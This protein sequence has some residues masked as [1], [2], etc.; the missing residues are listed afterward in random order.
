MLPLVKKTMKTKADTMDMLDDW[1]ISKI[2]DSSENPDFGFIETLYQTCS[3]ALVSL[4]KS[5]FRSTTHNRQKGILKKDIASIHFW[6]ENF[7]TGH[8]D[9]ILTESSDLKI[10]VLENLTGIGKILIPLFTDYGEAT[11]S[12]NSKRYSEVNFLKELNTQVEKATLMLDVEERSDPS[13]DDESDDFTPATERHQNR[14]GRLH[15]YTSC[16]IGLTPVVERYIWSLQRKAEIQYV[17][18]ETGFHS[19]HRAQ[20]YAMRIRD[21]FSNAAAALVERLAEANLERSIRLRTKQEGEEVDGHTNEDAVTLFKPFSLFHDSGLGTSIPTISQYAATVASHTSFISVAGEDAIGR[22]RVPSLPQ[23]GGRPFQ[24]EYCRKTISMRNRIEWKMHVFADLESYICTHDECKDALKTFPTRQ[25]WADHEFNEHFTL[26]QWRCFTCS[27]TLGSP[28]LYVEHLTQVHDFVL[29][30]HYLTAV[31]SEARET[32]LTPEFETFRC[33][34]CLQDG[35]Q[36]K[37]K[38]STHV[39]RHLEEIS[40]ACLP[41]DEEESTDDGLDTDLSSNHRDVD[42]YYSFTAASHESDEGYEAQVPAPQ[43]HPSLATVPEMESGV[44]KMAETSFP[45]KEFAEKDVPPPVSRPKGHRTSA[46][47]GLDVF[48]STEV[49]PAMAMPKA[50]EIDYES[51]KPTSYWSVAE[52][53]DFSRLLAHFGCDFVAISNFMKTKTTTM[54]RI[55]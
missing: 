44:G 41:R 34:L 18:I 42:D 38:Y 54:V 40:L 33:V 37:K 14:L 46:K 22:P 6:K 53:R 30:D 11:F 4:W 28:E 3:A 23:E 20:P 27:I 2:N 24:C 12:A 5:H 1:L 17:P 16:L 51:L 43:S 29:P 39:G 47:E 35:L 52:Q 55:A 15:S 7:P 26:P 9:T 49:E 48:K 10:R 36:T 21:R 19:S 45:Q 32:V 13:S 31:I 25:M 50:S 8:L